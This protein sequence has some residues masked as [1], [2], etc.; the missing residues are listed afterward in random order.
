MSLPQLPEEPWYKDGLKFKC[1]GCGKCCTGSPGYVWLSPEDISTLAKE[2]D[3]DEKTFLQRYT[4]TL[5]GRISLLEDLN[6]YDCIFLKNNR[7]TVYQARPKQCR[8]F[9]W[10]PSILSSPKAWNAVSE[11]CEGINHPE[12]KVYTP[13]EMNVSE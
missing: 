4:R 1:T 2:L 8:L 11:E 13:E 6:N 10:W 7:C 12:G 3:L 5:E 9:P